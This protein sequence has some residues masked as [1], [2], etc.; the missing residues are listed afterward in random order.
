MGVLNSFYYIGQML[1]SGI[2][3]P[4]GRIDGTA[5]WRAPLYMQCMPAGVNICFV[6]F[7]SESPRWL[8][9]QGK[10][11]QARTIMA[12]FHSRDNDKH[13]PL[14]DL[15]L[16]EFEENISLEGSDKQFWNFK[17]VFEGRGNKYRFG[18]CMMVSVWGQLAGNGL[19]TCR[20][21]LHTLTPRL[22]AH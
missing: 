22:P 12:K 15:E 3:I 4:F 16:A 20:S 19:L 5:A 14:I 2:S 10:E 13:S 21:H 17:T 9:A 8:F 6:L 11:D 7:I 18:L 1:A